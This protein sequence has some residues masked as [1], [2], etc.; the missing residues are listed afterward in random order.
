MICAYN[1]ALTHYD[2]IMDIP[3]NI[4][5]YC[6]IIMGH[7]TKKVVSTTWFPQKVVLWTESP[8]EIWLWRF[9]SKQ[10]IV[11]HNNITQDNIIFNIKMHEHTVQKRQKSPTYNWCETQSTK[12]FAVRSCNSTAIN[13]LHPILMMNDMLATWW[14]S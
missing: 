6:D 10:A 5:A 12:L 8:L 14:F 9:R 4:I 7:G 1:N 2:F 11:W 13:K 3:C